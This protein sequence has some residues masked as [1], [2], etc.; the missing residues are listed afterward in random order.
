MLVDQYG[1]PLAQVLPETSYQLPGMRGGW[2]PGASLQT[3]RQDFL[4]GVSRDVE[5]KASRVAFY[6]NGL[7]SGIA[8]VLQAFVVGDEFTY[9]VLDDKDAQLALDEFFAINSLDQLAERIW[10]EYLL[11]GESAIVFEQNDVGRDSPAQ[12]GLLDVEHVR[13]VEH[14][15]YDGVTALEFAAIDRVMRWEQGEFAWTAN[16][17]L[18]NDPR[19]WP[20]M[21]QAIQPALT[22]IGLIN[23]RMRTQE[24]QG[25]INGVYTALVYPKDPNAQGL[26]DAKAKTF[27]R[28]PRNG[29]IMTVAKDA[30][31][32]QKEELEYLT[33]NG[34]A[35]EAASD[36]RLIRMLAA[37]ALG[38]PPTWLGDA[39]DSNRASASVLN[40]PP[41]K[42]MRRRQSTFRSML[43]RTFRLELIRRFGPDKTYLVR[44]SEDKRDRQGRI[45]GKR[46][47][48]KRV[49]ADF[50]EIPWILPVIEDA[51][52]EEIVKK[53]DYLQ[54]SGDASR[55]TRQELLG[56]DVAEEAERMSREGG[57][58]D[59]QCVAVAQEEPA[60]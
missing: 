19:G 33:S 38:I 4:Y 32:G 11:D 50:L 14:N 16:K 17:A 18:Y 45:L 8:E 42:I 29:S 20:V 46:N 26:F 37:T 54:R 30:E 6:L 34:N 36:A 35:G 31:T 3:G 59:V 13:N 9:G 1:K 57:A 15:T 53:V 49:R 55:Q 2:T 25:R 43:T 51:S 22:Y 10:L 24:I 40:G 44:Y 41:L 52:L 21:M 23:T 39:E 12:I 7:V 58:Q 5:R 60:V 28:L 56:I 27:E 48:T 47:K